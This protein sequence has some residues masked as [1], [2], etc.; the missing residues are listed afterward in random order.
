VSPLGE[1]EVAQPYP[2][3]VVVG[4]FEVLTA[5]NPTDSDATQETECARGVTAA[6]DIDAASYRD[7]GVGGHGAEGGAGTGLVGAM[8][9][10]DQAPNA[11]AIALHNPAFV[12]V[13]PARA[14]AAKHEPSRIP[15]SDYPE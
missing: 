12:I 4:A 5:F 10:L 7:G 9:C 11:R 3:A 15:S 8:P 13:L 6:T 1:V 14:I 2:V